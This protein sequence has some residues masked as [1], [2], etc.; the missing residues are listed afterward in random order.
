[1]GKGEKGGGGFKQ[2]Q[3]NFDCSC[4][5]ETKTIQHQN[6]FKTKLHLLFFVF[7]FCFP[8][9]QT[10]APQM[11]YRFGS[12]SSLRFALNRTYLSLLPFRSFSSSSF[13]A[14]PTQEK[15][16]VLYI[17]A[18]WPEPTSSAAGVCLLSLHLF[19]PLFFFSFIF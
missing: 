11:A 12:K 19:V 15:L 6:K 7:F 1:M 2:G 8:S 14:S 16:R 18:V 17:G 10:K 9:F 5:K 4:Q 3:K 13:L